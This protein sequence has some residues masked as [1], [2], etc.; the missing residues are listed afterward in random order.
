VAPLVL[1]SRGAAGVPAAVE[2]L[3]APM[4]TVAVW[5]GWEET[6][7]ERFACPCCGYLTLTEGPPGSW[8][9]CPVCLWQDDPEGC[10]RSDRPHGPN[11]MSLKAA[12]SNFRLF[13]ACEARLR[14]YARRPLPEER[15]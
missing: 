6:V 2:D 3:S 10:A 14:K 15:P 11:P 7:P 5:R 4:R 8:E 9:I 1:R 12:R 13:G